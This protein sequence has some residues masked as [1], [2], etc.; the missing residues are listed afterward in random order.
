V[1]G[2]ARLAVGLLNQVTAAQA[3]RL[4]AWSSRNQTPVALA[5]INEGD[6]PDCLSPDTVPP[7][8]DWPGQYL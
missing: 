2:N 6:I 3:R 4:A 1:P 7:G 5:T 8:D